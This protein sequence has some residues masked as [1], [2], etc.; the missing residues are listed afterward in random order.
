V[1]LLHCGNAS[2]EECIEK[3]QETSKDEH[4]IITKLSSPSKRTE[5]E[6]ERSLRVCT[7]MALEILK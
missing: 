5:K 3:A 7:N 6:R 1:L 2:M 4:T